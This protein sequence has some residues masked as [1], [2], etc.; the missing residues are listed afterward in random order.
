M[1][2]EIDISKIKNKIRVAS[3]W[4]IVQ[5]Q[6]RNAAFRACQVD[7]FADQRW[8]GWVVGR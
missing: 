5:L 4:E 3:E 2:Q 7:G 6:G 8:F 1:E